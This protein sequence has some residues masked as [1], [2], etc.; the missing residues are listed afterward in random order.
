M[1]NP[2]VCFPESFCLCSIRVHLVFWGTRERW[3]L[4]CLSFAEAVCC[5]GRCDFVMRALKVGGL[6]YMLKNHKIKVCCRKSSS[7]TRPALFCFSLFCSP[8]LFPQNVSSCC[9]CTEVQF[10][11]IWCIPVIK[12]NAFHPS[13]KDDLATSLF[14]TPS[15]FWVLWCYWSLKAAPFI[16]NWWFHQSGTHTDTDS[17]FTV[18]TGQLADKRIHDEWCSCIKEDIWFHFCTSVWPTLEGLLSSPSDISE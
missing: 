15:V 17:G 4:L 8:S 6:V 9:I 1:F 16:L 11:T 3:L 18:C 10:L 12:K 14:L 5:I 2:H 7:E 13:I